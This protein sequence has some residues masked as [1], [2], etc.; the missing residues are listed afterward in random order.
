MSSEAKTIATAVNVP[1]ELDA[2]RALS[3]EY[4]KQH[5]DEVA[6]F[7]DGRGAAETAALLI[8]TSAPL[9]AAQILYWF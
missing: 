1:D 2:A 4:L 8:G 9:P 3:N 5:P 6:H 7:L